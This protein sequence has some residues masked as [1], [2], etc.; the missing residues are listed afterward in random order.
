MC[1]QVFTKT[2]IESIAGSVQCPR[3]EKRR[4]T[5]RSCAQSC[6]PSILGTGSICSRKCTHWS[7][8]IALRHAWCGI[9]KLQLELSGSPMT[10]AL[11]SR[12]AT[13]C[14]LDHERP[15]P[16]LHLFAF[17]AESN[18][19]GACLDASLAAAVTCPG[20]LGAS[21]LSSLRTHLPPHATAAPAAS[22]PAASAAAV[23]SSRTSVAE[24]STAMGTA[25]ATIPEQS[26][27]SQAVVP[28]TCSCKSACSCA[29]TRDLDP[30]RWLVAVDAA[31]ACSGH[32]PDLS[33]GD[34]DMVVIA[35]SHNS[36]ILFL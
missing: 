34:I 3:N 8:P 21:L 11:P 17:P 19:S 2:T 10:R 9:G 23:S 29:G 14:E 4:V 12:P 22:A 15:F 7:Y 20:G 27:T 18:Y 35:L 1:L 30:A 16:L 6:N 13:L 31:K 36:Q 24:Q 26:A 25:I 5:H 28:E 33:K 32:P